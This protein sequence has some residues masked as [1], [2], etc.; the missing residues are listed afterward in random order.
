MKIVSPTVLRRRAAARWSVKKGRRLCKRN[1]ELDRAAREREMQ[2]EKRE[3]MVG[4]NVR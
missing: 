4:G 2:I 3:R 1:S